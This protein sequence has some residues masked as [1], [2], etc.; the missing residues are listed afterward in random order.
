MYVLGT[1]F[2][3]LYKVTYLTLTNIPSCRYQ[4]NSILQTR[5]HPVQ[6]EQGRQEHKLE[7]MQSGLGPAL[8]NFLKN[9]AQVC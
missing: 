5:T 3:S 1:V 9:H 6:R 8:F 7:P 2:R 4:H